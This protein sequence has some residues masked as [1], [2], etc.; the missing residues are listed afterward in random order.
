MMFKFSHLKEIEWLRSSSYLLTSQVLIFSASVLTL[1]LLARILGPANYGI[2][3]LLFVMTNL[4]STFTMFGL[5]HGLTRHLPG[6]QK[7]EQEQVFS[8][9]S[10]ITFF[11][12]IILTFL[13]LAP[14]YF[15]GYLEFLS[16]KLVL[17]LSAYVGILNSYSILAGYLVG[18]TQ[19]KRVSIYN[20]IKNVAAPVLACTFAYIILI[21]GVLIG[22][23][24]AVVAAIAVFHISDRSKP[25]LTWGGIPRLQKYIIYGFPLMLNTIPDWVIHSLDRFLI[26]MFWEVES[27][28]YYSFALAISKYG[29]IMTPVIYTSIF[30]LVMKMWDLGKVEEAHRLIKSAFCLSLVIVLIAEFNICYFFKYL[31]LFFGG[32]RFSAS[33]KFILPL[34]LSGVF[35]TITY[36]STIVFAVTKQ[37]KKLLVLLTSLAV[38]SG[39]MNYLLIMKYGPIM[40]AY[41]YLFVF[42]LHGL[43][44]MA[45]YST[46]IRPFFTR[47]LYPY[48]IAVILFILPAAFPSVRYLGILGGNVYYFILL[49]VTV[50]SLVK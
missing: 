12:G 34:A 22:W 8:T 30:P 47:D 41:V 38:L 9:M 10:V 1:P 46:S 43:A 48:M 28:G 16:F 40:A 42:I 25:L 3:A 21:E 4:A 50:R 31:Y 33:A 39:P 49:G 27:V 35:L 18:T 32:E 5:N 29:I 26:E 36:F 13:V 11:S 19:F 14:L 23:V 20:T 2:V 44:S 15:A 7:E 45:V 37:T 6:M 24:L 17:L